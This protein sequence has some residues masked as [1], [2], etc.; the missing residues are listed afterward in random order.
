MG[1]RERVSLYNR[2]T[3]ERIG[4]VTPFRTYY[5]IME[6]TKT[7]PIYFQLLEKK[8][9]ALRVRNNIR[10]I[11]LERTLNDRGSNTPDQ[12]FRFLRLFRAQKNDPD[13]VYFMV[14][15]RDSYKNRPNPEKS[16]L[17]FLNRIKNAPVRLIV[18]SPCFELWLLLHRLNAYRDLILP[19]QEAIFQNE[20][21]SSGYTYISKMVKDLF[22]FNPKSMIPDFFL[23]GLNNALKQSPLLTSDPVR[24]ATEI[25]ENIGDFIAELMQ[26]VRY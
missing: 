2:Y 12:L 11:Y 15:D 8:L 10:L 7:E 13:A 5:L 6:G 26:D 25:G 20:R 4:M 1:L 14:F 16:Y 24:M 23:N 18:S 3:E 19:D 9:L 17:D 21:L 22:G